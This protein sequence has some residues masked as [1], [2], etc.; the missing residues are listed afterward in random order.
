[1]RLRGA[2]YNELSAKLGLPKSTL[3]GWLANVQLSVTSQE[4]IN[5]RVH[6]GSLKGL[7]RRN[8]NQTHLAI[9]RSRKTR[10][11]WSGKV[12]SL[13]QSELLLLGAALYWGEGYKRQKIVKGKPRTDHPVSLTNCDPYLILMF[14]RF[15]KEIFHVEDSS[16]RVMVHIYSHMSIEKSLEYWQTITHLP[17]EN[18]SKVYRGISRASQGKKPYNRLPYGTVQIRVNSTELF[19]KIMGLIDGLK[20]Q[21]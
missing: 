4:R 9:Q 17:R 11:E 16:I 21:S 6:E 13:S 5:K 3:Y 1:M 14:I 10:K 2:S 19:Y 20:A 12:S 7:I 8:Q 18:F 15:L